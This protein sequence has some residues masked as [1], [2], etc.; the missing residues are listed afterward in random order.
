MSVIV[1]KVGLLKQNSPKDSGTQDSR[2]HGYTPAV[3]PRT[4]YT[5]NYRE[6]Y[7]WLSHT[8]FVL[9]SFDHEHKFKAPWMPGLAST[10]SPLRWH[11]KSDASS[12]ESSF[13][14][15]GGA[16]PV[17]GA[18]G[19]DLF[20]AGEYPLHWIGGDYMEYVKVVKD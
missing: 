11:I 15:E 2:Q 16:I 12:Q 13:G 10:M 3:R 5:L 4:P 6:I 7:I 9:L 8:A 1:R 19:V 14:L 20:N 18:I 17:K